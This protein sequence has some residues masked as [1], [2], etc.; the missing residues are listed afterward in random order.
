MNRPRDEDVA[1]EWFTIGDFDRTDP[2]NQGAIE[3]AA[4]PAI[5]RLGPL[6]WP[7]AS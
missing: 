6:S 5:A 7:E 1:P 3:A 2:A 4:A